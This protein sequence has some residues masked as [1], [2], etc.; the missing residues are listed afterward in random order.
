MAES[1]PRHGAMHPTMKIDG[2]IEGAAHGLTVV[3]D[4]F[5]RRINLLM[6]STICSSSVRFI[7]VALNPSAM[8]RWALFTISEGRSPPT[9]A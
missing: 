8:A 7:L 3:G 9:Q 1:G 4:M 2:D 6:L 5:N